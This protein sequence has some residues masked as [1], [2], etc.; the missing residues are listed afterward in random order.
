MKID[1]KVSELLRTE[2]VAGTRGAS[3]RPNVEPVAPVTRTDRVR[4]SEAGRALAAA[5][6]AAG[7]EGGL[8]AERVAGLRQRVQDGTYNSPAV[9]DR[10]ARRLVES[11]DL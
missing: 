4:I 5:Q 2:H 1:N 10:I 6:E 7:A 11:G 8:S 3:T 9:A